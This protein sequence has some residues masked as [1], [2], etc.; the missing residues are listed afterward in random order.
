MIRTT[1]LTVYYPYAQERVWEAITG[2]DSGGLR[3]TQ[4][5]AEQAQDAELTL[6]AAVLQATEFTPCSRCALHMRSVGLETDWSAELAAEENGHTKVTYRQRVEY[7]T[8]ALYLLAPLI[9]N[10][11][12]QLA[13]FSREIRRKLAGRR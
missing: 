8:K 2:G 3:V 11:H 5:S 13:D 1:E 7:A 12:K 10:P 4:M 6:G 9:M